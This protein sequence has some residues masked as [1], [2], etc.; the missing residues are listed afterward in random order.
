MPTCIKCNKKVGLLGGLLTFNKTTQKCSICEKLVKLEFEKFRHQFLNVFQ[1]GV[2]SQQKF[3]YLVSFSKQSQIN[4]QDALAF[5]RGDAIWFLEKQLTFISADGIIT[6]QEA[7]HFRWL[8]I[9]FQIPDALL[10]PLNQRLKYL[11]YI[12]NIRQGNLPKF[13]ATVHL[14]SDEFCHLEILANYQ[15]VNLRSRTV[16]PGRLIATNKKIHFLSQNGGWVVLWKN[17]MRVQ[18]ESSGI[19]LEL[20]VKSGNG[21]YQVVNPSE[22]EAIITTVAR[23]NKR[24]LINSQSDEN[25]SRHIP[26]NVKTAV[27]QRD[28]GKCVQCSLN[29]YLEFDHIIPFSKGGANTVNNIQLLCRNCNLKKGNKL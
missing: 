16:I 25:Q 17:V 27:W 11:Q 6:E 12:S 28:Q 22:A 21:F 20:S 5:V 19:Y 24:Q 1:D 4:W 3:D 8:T 13:K 14:D 10:Q 15:K 7:Q 23:L 2:F 26:Q 29:S 18:T 9:N